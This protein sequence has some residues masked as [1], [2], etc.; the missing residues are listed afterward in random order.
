VSER[1][2][3]DDDKWSQWQQPPSSRAEFRVADVGREGP[4]CKTPI[5]PGGTVGEN[6]PHVLKVL[7]NGSVF[8]LPFFFFFVL[9]FRPTCRTLRGIFS[10]DGPV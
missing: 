7:R 3:A 2:D 6:F 5:Y 1:H 4:R 8:L 10:G 9:F